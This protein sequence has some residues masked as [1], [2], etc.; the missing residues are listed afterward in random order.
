LKRFEE[1]DGLDDPFANPQND[2]DDEGGDDDDLERRLAGIDLGEFCLGRAWPVAHG[3]QN[4][5]AESASADKIWAALT[6]EERA[7]FTRAVQDP[8]SELA[9]T[10]LTK[11]DLADDVPTPWWV[12]SSSTLQANAPASRPTLPPEAMAIPESLLAA[13]TSPSP[14]FPLAYNLVAILWVAVIRPLLLSQ[15]R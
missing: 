4:A 8:A 1:E 12:A 6:P 11:L 13:P 10:L 14:T 9:K 3:H 2:D 15:T 5:S 7:R